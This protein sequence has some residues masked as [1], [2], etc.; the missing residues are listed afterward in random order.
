MGYNV[1][2]IK[3]APHLGAEIR[4]VDLSQ[5]LSDEEFEA[6]HEA[7][8]EN[9]VVVFHDQKI[10]ADQQIAFGKR[11]GELSVHPF[12][13]NEEDTPELIIFDNK[14]DNP[15]YGT[16]RWHSDETFRA[17]PPLGTMLSAKIVP[18]YGGNTIF[19][20]MTAAY[21]ALSDKMQH[22]LD[23]L[24]AVHDMVL[25]RKL[26]GDGEEGL[27][28]RRK[29][30]ELYPNPVHPVV[31]IHPITG[32][33]AL[34]VNP[35]FTLRI[36]NM[37]EDES[38]TLLDWLFRQAEI[39]EL[40]YRHQWRVDSFVFWD[41]RSAQHYAPHDYYPQRR[42]MERITIQGDRP[43][44]PVGPTYF[45]KDNPEITSAEAE[46]QDE[47]GGHRVARPIEREKEGAA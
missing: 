30:E 13:P 12:S 15:P 39:P 19:A 40:Q 20:S 38:R 45:L 28:T 46:G 26:F 6:V 34:F 25:F 23:D 7:W 11:F 9:E 27:A 2:V 42:Y 47:F 14:K 8:V 36:K 5:A 22:F 1:E 21:D 4:G 41:N 17:E 44:G 32:K 33:K 29:Y 24:E 35:Q 37:R 43:F 10:N 18:A 16:D 3:V 31:R